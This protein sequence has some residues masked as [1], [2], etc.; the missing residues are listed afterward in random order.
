[1]IAAA[2]DLEPEPPPPGKGILVLDEDRTVLRAMTRVLEKA[3][4]TVLPAARCDEAL[5]LWAAFGSLLSLVITDLGDPDL[6][7][8]P[9]GPA[10]IAQFLR[11]GVA[12]PLLVI[13]AA[14]EHTVLRT[15][16]ALAVDFLAKP[17]NHKTLLH[18]VRAMLTLQPT[19]N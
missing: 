16:P 8:P 11:A 19:E 15:F 10:F 18:R 5:E 2:Y 13:A 6:H 4:Y 1:M 3:G 7:D 9:A 14:P 17:F 12:T